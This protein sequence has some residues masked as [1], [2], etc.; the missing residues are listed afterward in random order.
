MRLTTANNFS[1][2]CR[3]ASL[4]KQ[5]KRSLYLTCVK[6]QQNEYQNGNNF[7]A[8]YQRLKREKIGENTKGKNFEAT[9]GNL[10]E[11]YDKFGANDKN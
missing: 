5:W 8:K 2:L 6:Q 9:I 7:W 4:Q 1:K 3:Q 10:L 11:N